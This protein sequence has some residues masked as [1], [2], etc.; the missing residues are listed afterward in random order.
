MFA[1]DIMQLSIGYIF[2]SGSA[3]LDIT[4]CVTRKGKLRSWHGFPLSLSTQLL[5]GVWLHSESWTMGVAL[6]SNG[7]VLNESEK[8]YG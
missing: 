4:L 2:G 3:I 1:Q 7:F 8:R 5:G 6:R